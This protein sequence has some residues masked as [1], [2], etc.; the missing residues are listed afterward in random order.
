MMD[1]LRDETSSSDALTARAAELL[2]AMQPLDATRRLRPPE[3]PD[4]G[5]RRGPA[6]RIPASLVLAVTLA[7]VAAAAATVRTWPLRHSETL[8]PAEAPQVAAASSPVSSPAAGAMARPMSAVEA[9]GDGV[10]APVVPEP[11]PRLA[12]ATPEPSPALPVGPGPAVS[13]RELVVEDE[14]T[15]MVS[16]VRA[17][18][19]EGDPARAQMLAQQ[20]LQR[21][22]HGAQAEEA[23]AL[24]MEAASARGDASGAQQAAAAYLARFGSGRFADRAR[25]ILV[26]RA[27]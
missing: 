27:K 4:H 3:L 18:R 20:A 23:M 15:L 24:I 19:R 13:Q 1:R 12:P 25:R 17:L 6:A 7:S 10:V 8:H 16:A 9:T 5:R 2:S 26:S 11:G 14:S 22:P 21:F